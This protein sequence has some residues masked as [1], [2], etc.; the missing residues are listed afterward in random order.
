MTSPFAAAMIDAR[1]ARA[2][3]ALPDALPADRAAAFAAQVET[4]DG[5]GL[6]V[7]GFKVG[8]D[9][10]TGEPS[11]A[12]L[13]TGTV[14]RDHTRIVPTA[15]LPLWLE[16]EVAMVVGRDLACRDGLTEA[17]VLDAMEGLAAAIE[18]VETRLAD[19]P[20]VPKLAAMADFQANGGT[21]VSAV[22]R[23][24]TGAKVED[25]TVIFE[26]GSV[27]M[28]VPGTKYP[29][30]DMNRLPTWLA[31]NMAGWG[32]EMA[33]RGLKKGDV[34]ITG[35]WVGVIPVQPGETATVTV[36]GV[37]SVSVEVAA[38]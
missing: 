8:A 2:R 5:L 27:H 1:K 12:P 4:L 24:A 37:G 20:D 15:A 17:E 29:G 11:A 31:N 16:A 19:W 25:L 14:F 33:A 22:G 30:Q 34:I 10:R 23:A 7:A 9:G 21:V 26:M 13:A 32:P 38:G 18:I 6:G 3:T 28:E 36:P 35:S